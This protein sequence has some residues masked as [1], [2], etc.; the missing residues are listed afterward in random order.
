MA[1]ALAR[2][3]GPGVV[4]TAPLA[5]PSAFVRPQSVLYQ[6]DGAP[7]AHLSTDRCLR[8]LD[9]KSLARA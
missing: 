3:G 7:A 9:D 4:T 1:A 5:L 2:L 6:L 8:G